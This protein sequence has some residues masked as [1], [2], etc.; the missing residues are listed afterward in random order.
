TTK[1]TVATASLHITAKQNH[2]D[3]RYR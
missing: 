3:S 2:G 1:Q